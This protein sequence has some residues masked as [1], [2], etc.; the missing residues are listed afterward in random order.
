MD[1]QNARL[2]CDSTVQEMVNRHNLETTSP[3]Y[4]FDP[5]SWKSQ[6]IQPYDRA[7]FQVNAKLNSAWNPIG[8]N[9]L[10]ISVRKGEHLAEQQVTLAQIRPEN[11]AFY[12]NGSNLLPSSSLF[13]GLV[14]APEGLQ[15]QQPEVRFRDLAQGNF[16]PEDYA[17]FRKKSS[18]AFAY[19]AIDGIFSAASFRSSAV[20]SGLLISGKNPEFWT[21]AGYE[22]YLDQL[23]LDPSGKNWKVRYKS[24]DIAIVSNLLLWFDD[25]LMVH[26]AERSTPFL[27]A[28]KLRIPVYVGSA[29]EVVVESGLL[30]IESSVYVHPLSLISGGVIRIGP[31]VPQAC[32][33]ESCFI[34][35]GSD[36]SGAG[37]IVEPGGVSISPALKSQLLF[38]VNTSAFLLEDLKRDAIKS[39][40]EMNQKVVWF[41]GSVIVRSTLNFPPDL[42]QVH[43][44]SSHDTY[45]LFPSFPFVRVIEGSRQWR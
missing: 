19:P 7:G 15:F 34:A 18:T 9:E 45:P 22:L 20:T 35:L 13:D 29:L 8:P 41:R 24:K 36:I 23:Q 17:S 25:R 31:S 10:K 11:F 12:S 40:I 2:L 3:R 27:A 33:L 16:F 28:K 39:A 44:Q 38:E 4:F 26:Q 1:D 42:S 6:A 32:R 21:G 37:I 43:F 30:P 14:Y 5:A